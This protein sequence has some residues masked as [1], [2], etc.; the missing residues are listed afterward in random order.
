MVAN[1]GGSD[2]LRP[3]Q[4]WSEPW[5][6]QAPTFAN[7]DEISAGSPDLEEAQPKGHHPNPF[8][9]LQ[10]RFA[11]TTCPHFYWSRTASTSFTI[12]LDSLMFSRK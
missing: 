1:G 7:V 11:Q 9:A 3:I 8:F 10:T 12:S 6:Q 2:R 4:Q 5:G